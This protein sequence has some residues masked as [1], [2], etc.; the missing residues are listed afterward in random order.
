MRVLCVTLLKC[1]DQLFVC[2]FFLSEPFMNKLFTGVP[3]KEER[4][5]YEDEPE[6]ATFSK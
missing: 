5:E 3:V 4:M 2:F 6:V 1:L